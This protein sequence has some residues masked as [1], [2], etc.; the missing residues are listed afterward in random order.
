MRY[1]FLV[2][3]AILLV[4]PSCWAGGRIATVTNEPLSHRCEFRGDAMVLTVSDA[5]HESILHRYCSPVGKGAASIETDVRGQDFLLLTS[6][7]GHVT[8]AWTDYLTVYRLND[9]LAEVRRLKISDGAGLT[10]RWTYGYVIRRPQ[11]GGLILALTLRVDGND[12]DPS[13]IPHRRELAVL[14]E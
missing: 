11:R 13:A 7:E 4:A 10:A 5:G 6:T 2:L 8:N 12:V 3:S 1:V 9:R 14:I